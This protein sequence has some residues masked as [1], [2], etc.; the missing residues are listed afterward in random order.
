MVDEGDGM[1]TDDRIYWHIL[2][3]V[4]IADKGLAMDVVE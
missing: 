4:K 1:A 2:G 3:R